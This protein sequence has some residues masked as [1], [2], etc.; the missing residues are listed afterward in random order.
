MCVKTKRLCHNCLPSRKGCSNT[1]HSPAL[2]VP[3]SAEAP[4]TLPIHNSLQNQPS[5]IPSSHV[6]TNTTS[7]AP[8]PSVSDSIQ[9]SALASLPPI[10]AH[11]PSPTLSTAHAHV[12]PCP[13]PSPSTMPVPTFTWGEFD[14]A[15]IM[16]LMDEAYSEAVLGLETFSKSPLVRL[17]KTFASELSRLYLAYGDCSSLEAIA[18]KACTVMPILLL[19]KPFSSSK[20][21]EHSACIARRLAIWKKGDIG[22]LLAE[23]HTIQSRLSKLRPAGSQ[24]QPNLE[25]TF[26]KLM[27]QGKT[28]EALE[29][30]SKQGRGEILCADDLVE[31]GD[32]S[33]KTVLDILRSKHPTAEPAFPDALLEGSA[34][35]PVVHPVFFLPDHCWHHSSCCP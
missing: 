25:H 8:S 20:Q 34:N 9:A 21:K 7:S 19:Q 28:N 11:L 27:F 3:D 15:H 1:K 33:G 29:V 4:P 31:L 32:R 17:E 12:P 18:L 16:K 14:S 22:S 10:D 2:Q 35:P 24:D 26:S 13:L 30:L 5:A 6:T 23:C